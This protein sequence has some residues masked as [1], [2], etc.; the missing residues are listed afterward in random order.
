MR[1]DL[2]PQGWIVEATKIRSHLSRQDLQ[3]RTLTNTVCPDQTEY[4][5]GS[6]S[7][8]TMQLEAVRAETMRGLTSEV[9]GEINDLNGFER[10]SLNANTAADTESLRN[11]GDFR[12]LPDLNTQ[13]SS[14]Y[15]RT[16][17]STFLHTF[18][19]LALVFADDGNTE[20]L[21]IHGFILL[22]SH[23]LKLTDSSFFVE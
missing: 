15:N 3:G 16:R 23:V 18:L 2:R 9:L 19:R 7:R 20:S 6:W 5:T 10:A 14:P 17:L 13:F 12:V 4:L 11:K 1:N 21:L 22:L 8:K